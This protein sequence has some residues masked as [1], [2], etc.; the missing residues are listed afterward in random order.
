M[1]MSALKE[2]QK[3]ASLGICGSKNFSVHTLSDL[4]RIYF[5]PL[6]RA[7]LKISGFA[8][9][10]YM[11]TEAVSGKKKLWIQKYPD[12]C[13]RGLSYFGHIKKMKI[14]FNLY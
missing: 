7:D 4:L 13:G 9:A 1:Q 11:R 2:P 10:G 5:Y 3:P 8:T 14:I 6:W 12:T